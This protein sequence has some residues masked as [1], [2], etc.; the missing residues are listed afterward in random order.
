META[1]IGQEQA[2][3][4]VQNARLIWL[5]RKDMN[6]KMGSVHDWHR[7]HTQAFGSIDAKVCTSNDAGLYDGVQC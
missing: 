7:P 3:G 5:T 6:V 4:R 2:Q 1:D